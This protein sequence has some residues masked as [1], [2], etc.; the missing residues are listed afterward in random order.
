MTRADRWRQRARGKGIYAAL[1][2]VAYVPLLFTKPDILSADTKI[3]LYLDPGRLM[4]TALQMWD[5]QVGMGTVTH[6]TIGYLFPMGPYYW[7]MR[8]IGL[9]VWVAQRIWL[10]TLL[11]AAGAGVVY[12][13]RTLRWTG[14]AITVAAFVY[15]LSPYLLD[16]A[17]KHSVV[18]SPW[19]G[20]P[21]MVAFTI[22]AI[23]GKGWRDAA[24]FA[25]V[26][27]LIGGINATSLVFVLVGTTLWLPFCVWVNREATWRRAL[28]AYARIGLLTFVTSL[29]WMSGLWAQGR[30]G[31]DIL[32]FTETAKTVASTSSATEVLRGLGYWFVYGSD[33][34]GNFV[35]I[36]EPYTQHLWLI[37]T[38]LLL[39][40]LGLLGSGLG[41]FRDRAYFVALVVIGTILAVG[42]HPWGNPPVLGA[43]FRRLL[44]TSQA[45][46][47]MRSMPRAVPLLVLGLAVLLG[48]AVGALSARYPNGP[49]VLGAALPDR[50][51]LAGV[52]VLLLLVFV[53]YPPLFTGQLIAKYLQ[54]PQDIPSYW[55][56]DIKALDRQDNSTRVLEIPGSDFASY[57]WGT[58]VDPITP[59]LMSRDYVAR[60]LVPYGTPP[61]ADFL[62]A[63]DT[64]L[65]DGVLQPNAL[66]PIAR[67]MAAGDIN[68]RSDLTY[69]RYL[70]P[71]PRL[72][73]DLVTRAEG[74]GAGQGLGK[75][76][77]FGGTGSNVPDPR[78]PLLDETEL[79]SNPNLKNPPKVAIVPVLD[80]EPMVRAAPTSNP[81][82]L[83][84]DGYGTVYASEAQ[85]LTGHELLFYGG[86]FANDTAALQQ[87]LANGAALVLTDTDRK[88]A[89]RWGT[90]HDT[91]GYTER[92]GEKPLVT[93]P[94]DQRVNLFPT[95]TDASRTV[96]EQR[97]GV[98]ATATNYGNPV[99][100]TPEDRAANAVD[101]NPYTMW[102]V[103]GFAPVN[104]EQLNLTFG[105]TR[106]TDHVRLVQPLTGVRNRWLTKVALHFDDGPPVYE[107]LDPVSRTLAG[108][109]LTFPR[110]SFKKLTVE[111]VSTN[112]NDLKVFSG[113]GP[114]GIAE[115]DVGTNPPH[116]NE[117]I[118]LPTRTLVQAGASSDANALAILLTRQRTQPS[119]AV[120]RDEE[121]ALARIWNLPSRRSFAITGDV[122]IADLAS[123]ARI[124]AALGL[125][126]ASQGGVTATS[127]RHL[128]GDPGAR[129]SAALD[130]NPA[131]A[132]STG[133]LS[134][135]GDWTNYKLPKAV[136]FDHLDL[137][138]VADGRHSLPTRIKI[139]ADGKAPV[140]ALLGNVPTTSTPNGT[141][142]VHVTFPR[143]T[144]K[145]IRITIAGEHEVYTRDWY[146]T[147]NVALPVAIA[148]WG[149]PGTV[150]RAPQGALSSTCRSGLVQLDGHDVPIALHGTV[151]HATAGDPVSFT[152]CTPAAGVS[153]GKGDHV[154]R[155]T[156]GTRTGLNV[157]QVVLRS[158]P[159]GAADPSTG[160]VAAD[161][162]GFPT[163][164]GPDVRV[165]HDRHTA[166]DATVTNATKPFWLVFGESLDEGWHLRVNGKDQGPATLVNGYA[167]GWLVNPGAKTTLDVTLRWTPQRVI[168]V[169]IGIS[170]VALLGCFALVL[171]PMRRR[172][173]PVA[174]EAG[175]R[176]PTDSNASVPLPLDL[177]R[178][179]R[180]AGAPP[181]ARTAVL[182]TLGTALFWGVVI[183]PVVGL[184][185]GVAVA[186]A[187]R[188][189][190]ARPVFTLGAPLLLL[191]VA[192]YIM[193][194]QYRWH[195]PAGFEWPGYYAGTHQ[196]AW[197]SVALMATDVL[198]DRLWLRR[199][200][201][202][203]DSPA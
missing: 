5:P 6:Q 197:A 190:R 160:A 122:R 99:S 196:F 23:R 183:G 106:T 187:T 55:T 155:G 199:W 85:L 53:N 52:G 11:F 174:E 1:A 40:A 66:A 68:V 195:L 141:S 8:E 139:S 203:G 94:G 46:G 13:L 81:V 10:G 65:Q 124:D 45:G 113:T 118:R 114:V 178:L 169:A 134:A 170:A 54:H 26:V 17:A 71:R 64:T 75:P 156:P 188:V 41:R 63:F 173:A 149:I 91:T 35:Q 191:L 104:G 73:W 44:Q 175:S 164:T 34:Y 198:I 101:G 150:V 90:L 161:G 58:T 200:W 107:T 7:V 15:M 84:G 193:V 185:I 151:A 137:Q 127:S 21:W 97:G 152:A 89:E 140:T 30:Y 117:L 25:I 48:S 158:A 167:H 74:T 132:W 22:R 116:V 19:S 18:A 128:P 88:R 110:R 82:V 39:P 79:G 78:F 102:Q 126:P 38:S 92:A 120:R 194:E 67:F 112:R 202:T 103:G 157:D 135:V 171:W 172:L 59:G 148:E 96:S 181:S 186:I 184:A 14:S 50:R 165:L 20:F 143:V 57:R 32:R 154:L 51:V 76:T 86:T 12:L 61:S 36:G 93:D 182:V 177:R 146:S 42:A 119:N 83:V 159:G 179:V 87:Q 180:Y 60:E 130:G 111:V 166:V 192:A 153:L 121:I 145:N 43:I 125:P 56:Q 9:P 163:G 3:Y 142:T 136:S 138:V 108:Q 162:Q 144:G 24:L 105:R 69:E 189:A 49:K 31:I 2:F 131:T 4:R 72:L 28:G 77:G 47:A 133:F 29:W 27:Q 33:K 147:S 37:G 109:V 70:L 115:L 80:P 168:W 95:A 62:D 100:Y 98:V 123:D 129:A 201:P 16:Y 176:S